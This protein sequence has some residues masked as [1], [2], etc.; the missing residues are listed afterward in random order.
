MIIS[1]AVDRRFCELAGVMLASLFANGDIGDSRV[2]VFGYELRRKDKE[3]LRLS[4]GTERYRLEIIDVAASNPILRWLATLWPKN[5]PALFTRLLI[6]IILGR[7]NDRLLFLDC[8]MVVLSSLRPLIELE[9]GE[10]TIAAVPDSDAAH[11]KRE[12]PGTRMSYP[13]DAPYFNAG[14][15]LIDLPKWRERNVTQRVFDVFEREGK[16]LRL[17]DQDALNTA[18][19]GQ[20]KPLDLEWNVHPD[21]AERL[22]TYDTARIIHFGGQTKP[23]SIEC[24]S[25]QQPIYLH[26]RKLTP[27]NKLRLETA[28]DSRLARRKKHLARFWRKL[29]TRM[30]PTP[31]RPSAV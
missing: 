20:W 4:C 11:P 28:F 1:C 22:G 30:R 24:S 19:I 7:E 16:R 29:T 31:S 25:A 14:L 21:I 13:V 8:D 17:A 15:M 12:A 6:P 18:L 5:S 23:N 9:L 3:R 27:W 10:C 2:I 26:Y